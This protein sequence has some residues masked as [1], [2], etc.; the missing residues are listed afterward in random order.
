MRG[1]VYFDFKA[2]GALVGNHQTLFAVEL[3]GNRFHDTFAFACTITRV[4]VE[5]Q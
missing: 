5:M 3:V 1:S 2:L 4:N